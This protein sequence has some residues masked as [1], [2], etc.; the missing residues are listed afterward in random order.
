[1]DGNGGRTDEELLCSGNPED[2]GLFY[3]RHAREILGY[4]ARRTNSADA[5]ADLTSE[6]FA[7]AIVARRRFRPGAV[8]AVGWLYGIA[9]HKLADY[10]RRG[11]AE[12]RARK[13][14]GMER[15]TLSSQDVEMIHAAA[16]EVTVQ[17][18]E[19]LP[20]DQAQAVRAHV[21]DDRS[22][23]EI[24]AE[25]QTSEQVIRKR[26]SRGLAA[27]RSRAGGQR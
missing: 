5:A 2:F 19:E 4:F 26:V 1:M 20:T 12:E 15:R 18:I 7:A 22:Y 13:R 14:L 9:A 11:R 16:L 10:H 23:E 24:A 25:Q 6:T 27:L 3:R 8:P 21:I 17:I